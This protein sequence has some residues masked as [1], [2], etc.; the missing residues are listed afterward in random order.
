MAIEMAHAMRQ[1]RITFPGYKDPVSSTQ[2]T[3]Q[4]KHNG[5][6]GKEKNLD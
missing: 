3:A 4:N 1:G 5:N 2:T 6:S